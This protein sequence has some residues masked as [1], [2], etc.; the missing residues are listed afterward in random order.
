MATTTTNYK[1]IKPVLTDAPDITQTNPN[2][3]L[4]DQM[5]AARIEK[6]LIANNLLSDNVNT[7]L[8]APQGKILKAM[9]DEQNKNL[10]KIVYGTIVIVGNGTNKIDIL[11]IG[12]NITW[13]SCPM[14][15]IST[16]TNTLCITAVQGIDTGLR[17]FFNIAWGGYG[18]RVNYSYKLV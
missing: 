11:N 7:V 13:Q 8:A 10:E 15:Q 2:W 16:E 6:A 18:I 17:L 1:L 12:T 3:D 4:I 9:I 14:A 5:I